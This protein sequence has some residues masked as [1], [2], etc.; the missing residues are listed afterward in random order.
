MTVSAAEGSLVIDLAVDTS[1]VVAVL[2]NEPGS[3]A[4]L[5]RLCAAGQPAVAAPTRTE[6]LLVALAKLGDLGLE[7]ARDFL[8]QQAILTVG[9]DQEL[10][11]A[12]A[13]AYQRFGKGHH[14]SGLNFGDCFA[15]ALADHLKVP[16]LFVGNDFSQTDLEPALGGEG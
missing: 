16:L 5:E 15:Y 8:E 13:L 9:W 11:D 6:I 7:R 10:A 1:A 14:P 12:A 2:L 3:D 4:V